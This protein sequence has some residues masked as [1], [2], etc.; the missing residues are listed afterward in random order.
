MQKQMEM[1]KGISKEM[2]GGEVELS[3][4][5]SQVDEA[6]RWVFE[7]LRAKARVEAALAFLSHFH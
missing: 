1:Q 7:Q 4:R 5:A 6:S 2:K 3:D